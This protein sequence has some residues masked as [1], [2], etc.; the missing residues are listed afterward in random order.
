[1]LTSF[2]RYED[3]NCGNKKG[4]DSLSEDRTKVCCG[5]EWWGLVSIDREYRLAVD[6]YKKTEIPA[7]PARLQQ[8][9]S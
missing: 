4:R 7:A 8:M 5:Q 1:M 9:S 3:G 2:F 6:A